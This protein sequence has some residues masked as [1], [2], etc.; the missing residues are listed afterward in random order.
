MNEKN[1]PSIWRRVGG[2]LLDVVELYAPMV[3]FSVMFLSFVVGIFFRYALNHPLTWPHELSIL[4]FIWTTMLGACF[5]RRM[6]SH[7]AFTLIY[8]RVSPRSQLWIR[9]LG[10]S[11]IAAA[12]A[13]AFYKTADFVQFMSFQKTPVL[14]IPF[15]IGY[16]PYLLFM[17]FIFARI[18]VD[19]VRD[20]RKLL[21]GNG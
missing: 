18:S 3:S 11:L 5:A 7:V 4:G 9:L 15:N 12:F 17:V 21:R 13:I 19:L 2:F 16:F 20:V 10:N 6:G 14:R 1:Y 8:D